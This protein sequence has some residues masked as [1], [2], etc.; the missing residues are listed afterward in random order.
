M[1]VHSFGLEINKYLAQIYFVKQSILKNVEER[2]LLYVQNDTYVGKEPF[3]TVLI[4]DT[5]R[6]KT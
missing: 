6:V 5:N 3:F 2:E 1:R 4:S